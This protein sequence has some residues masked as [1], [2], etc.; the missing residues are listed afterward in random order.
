MFQ[1][2]SD[3]KYDGSTEEEDEGQEKAGSRWVNTRKEKAVLLLV[4]IICK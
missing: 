1:S 3:M 2:I 4:N